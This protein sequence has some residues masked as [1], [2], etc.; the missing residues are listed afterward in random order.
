MKFKSNQETYVRGKQKKRFKIRLKAQ[1]KQK[2]ICLCNNKC[3]YHSQNV[4]LTFKQ[5]ET[6]V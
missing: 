2:L 5:I 4:I 3:L 1:V 6:F